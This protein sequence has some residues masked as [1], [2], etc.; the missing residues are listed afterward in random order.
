MQTHE[1]DDSHHLLHDSRLS[2]DD[3]SDDIDDEFTYDTRE[4]GGGGGGGVGGGRRRRGEVS[5]LWVL[6][7]TFGVELLLVQLWQFWHDVFLLANPFLVG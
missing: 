2:D 7:R 6:W 5:L 4:D 1:P 3:S